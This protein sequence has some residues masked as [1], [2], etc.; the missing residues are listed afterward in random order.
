M[1]YGVKGVCRNGVSLCGTPV[2]PDLGGGSVRHR[3]MAVAPETLAVMFL[4]LL[5]PF[6]NYVLTVFQASLRH[7]FDEQFLSTFCETA[8]VI[9]TSC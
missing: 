7:L 2:K 1:R 6:K 9:A 3:I 8:A 4:A 5:F